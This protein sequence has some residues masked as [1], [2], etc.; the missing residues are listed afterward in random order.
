MSP[1]SFYLHFSANQF[2]SGVDGTQIRS[3]SG[4]LAFHS[5]LDAVSKPELLEDAGWRPGRTE[6]AAPAGSMPRGETSL[7]QRNAAEEM[8]S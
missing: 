1:P 4:N 2:Q 8:R 7:P 5:L 6:R 3:S